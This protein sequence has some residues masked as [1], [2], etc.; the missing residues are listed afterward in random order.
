MTEVAATTTHV[1]PADMLEALTTAWRIELGTDPTQAQICTLLAQWAL[2]TGGGQSMQCYNVGNFKRPDP[3]CGDWCG[4]STTE[5]VHGQK[6]TLHPPDPGTRFAAYD[7]L[8]AGCC[9]YIH[10]L[11]HHWAHAWPA[12]IAGD[13]TR[14]ALLLHEEGYYTADPQAY[15]TGLVTWFAKLSAL[16]WTPP[17]ETA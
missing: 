14:F 6:V 1:T 17:E 13:P 8:A 7:S 10:A 16:P 12:V 2:E 11:S 4:F 9:D 5:I 15:A 3:A